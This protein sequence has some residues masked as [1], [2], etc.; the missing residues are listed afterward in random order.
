[1]VGD[2]ITYEMLAHGHKARLVGGG[3]AVGIP[4]LR[5]A[6]SLA[7]IRRE[8]S[9]VRPGGVV[10]LEL[11]TNDLPSMHPSS[12]RTILGGA[13]GQIPADRCV[14]LVG[15]HRDDSSYTLSWNQAIREVLL[16]RR[17]KAFVDWSWHIMV[18]RAIHEPPLL[19]ADGI[20]LTTL[21]EF[22]LS[23]LIEKARTTMKDVS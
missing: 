15:V 3:N 13:V 4:G 16:G 2:S 1:M 21:G 6:D 23:G 10:I 9:K 12:F 19:K 22:H 20:H 8:A 5:M 18:S 17:C 14:V 11:G 7:L